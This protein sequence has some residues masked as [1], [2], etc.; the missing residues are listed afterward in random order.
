MASLKFSSF[1]D[2]GDLPKE[3]LVLRAETDLNIGQ[4]A[5]FRSKKSGNGATAGNKSAYWFPDKKLKRGDLV[6]LY[7][8]AGKSSVKALDETRTAHFFYWGKTDPIWAGDDFGAAIL[9]VESWTFSVPQVA[10]SED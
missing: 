4:F 6:V 3:R 1:A 2:R 10:P 8:K 9:K 5:I 7:S